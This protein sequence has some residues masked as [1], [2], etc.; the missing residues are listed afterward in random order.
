MHY[1]V[2]DRR[3]GVPIFVFLESDP[4]KP[5]GRPQQRGR[6]VNLKVA[7]PAQAGAQTSALRPRGNTAIGGDP[8][9]PD[10]YEEFAS[11]G[12]VRAA[13]FALI[14]PRYV[15]PNWETYLNVFH[16]EGGKREKHSRV[17]QRVGR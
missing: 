17:R 2:I 12:H 7:E 9:R 4:N 8:E 11:D 14:E 1:L 16:P 5:E 13:G 15:G 3:F 6:W 10:C